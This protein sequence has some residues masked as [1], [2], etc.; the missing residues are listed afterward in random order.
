MN[1]FVM[2]G[3]TAW[4]VPSTEKALPTS[5]E[6]RNFVIEDDGICNAAP[7]TLLV[8]KI[9]E[10]G[11]AA[12]RGV[13]R[14]GA[15]YFLRSKQ[16]PRRPE[17]WHIIYCLARP[18]LERIP[19]RQNIC[20]LVTVKTFKSFLQFWIKLATFLNPYYSHT[21]DSSSSNIMI[22]I[23]NLDLGH[24]IDTTWLLPR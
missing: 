8:F 20:Y 11:G 3:N 9:L 23:G 21:Q 2:R 10:S 17:S 24:I 4:S 22:L 6:S 15:G 1:G 13:A 18:G 12:W 7:R 5:C 14:R 16:T 19:S